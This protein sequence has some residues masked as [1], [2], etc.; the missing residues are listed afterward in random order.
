VDYFSENT[1]YIVP[2]SAK[3]LL[4]QVFDYNQIIP[5]YFI[6]NDVSGQIQVNPAFGR[7]TRI[8]FNI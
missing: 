8:S 4:G 2:N 6:V 1:G 7:W 5:T 3:H